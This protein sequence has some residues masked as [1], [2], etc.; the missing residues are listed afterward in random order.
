MFNERQE[1]LSNSNRSWIE[2]LRPIIRDF[3]DGSKEPL[4]SQEVERLS[5]IIRLKIDLE[6]GN[7]SIDDLDIAIKHG[8]THH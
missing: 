1:K 5:L 8:S 4:T 6:E 2:Q 3:K 7:V